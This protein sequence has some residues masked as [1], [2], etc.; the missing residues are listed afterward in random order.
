MFLWEMLRLNL[1]VKFFTDRLLVQALKYEDAEEIFY[2]YAS[3]SIATRYV[4]WP[5]HESIEDTR[6]FLRYVIPAWKNGSEYAFSI[7]SADSGRMV[8]SFG[9]VNDH[10][11][12]QFGYIFSPSQWGN[13]YATEVCK[14]MMPLLSRQEGV[15][16]IQ[17][18]V[19]AENSV[20]AR[21]LLKSGLI[22]EARLPGWFKFINQGNIPKDCILFRLPRE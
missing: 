3:K 6:K 9:V 20:S 18:F 4:S 21:V 5:T 11:K 16:R 13:G 22:E 12:L 10:G 15:Y 17:S 8:G 7:R 14:A 1:P 2:G 19:D